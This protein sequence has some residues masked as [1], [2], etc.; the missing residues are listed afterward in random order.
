MR[1]NTSSPSIA[2][3]YDRVNTTYG[4][5]ENVLQS[6][7]HLFPTAPIFTSVYDKAKATWANAM[8]VNPSFLQ[9]FPGAIHNH[10]EYVGLMPLAFENLDLDAFDIIISV[11]SAEAKGVLT[12]PHQL[13][14]CYLLTPTRYLWSHEKEYRQ[15]F[16]A[17]VIKKPI[18]TYL[19][20]W[21][22]AAAKRPDVIIPISSTV[23]KRC[24]KYYSRETQAVIYPP[25]ELTADTTEAQEL[26]APLKSA[27]FT[28]GEYYLV[29][30][31]LV[32]YKRIDLAIQACAELG[33][34]LVI[35]GEGPE[36]ASLEK[37]A[38]NLAEKH[39]K[40]TQ[41]RTLFLQAVQCTVLTAYYK[42][43]RAFLAPGEED[44]G[45]AALEAHLF[46]KPAILHKQSGAAEISPEGFSS[47]QLEEQS[48][49]AV[50]NAMVT[51]EQHH[52]QPEKI[53]QHI[54]K[55]R[56]EEFEKTFAQQVNALWKSWKGQYV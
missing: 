19:K 20:W 53:R 33:R 47:V 50:K 42:N 8:V 16:L 32:G 27:G 9:N 51:T 11:T 18:F 13:H 4:G 17:E 6:L 22:V 34:N 3:I 46:G 45:I 28:S 21:D 30:A 15:G 55:Y 52:W 7:H 14:I 35:I 39:G 2:I 43:C 36:R 38:A 12:K 56:T 10:R 24:Q 5:A 26:P 48:S 29:V 37:M 40:L 49:E 1:T 41:T 54:A 44:F 31:R 25:V 23:A